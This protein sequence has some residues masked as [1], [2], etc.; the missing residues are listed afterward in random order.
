MPRHEQEK[1]SQNGRGWTKA[2]KVTAPI[3]MED[4]MVKELP[5]SLD[6]GDMRKLSFRKDPTNEDLNRVK[7]KIR[8]LDHLKKL[9][10]VL[11]ARLTIDQ[12]LTGKNI[13]TGP[14]QYHFTQT[15]FDG[16]AIRI[17]DLKST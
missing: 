7:R 10:G 14:N 9:L 8:I 1:S 3:S 2:R 11:P 12:G 16:E 15:L 17:F 13:T 4:L 5:V 6:D